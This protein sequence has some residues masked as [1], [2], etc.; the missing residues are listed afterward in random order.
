MIGCEIGEFGEVLVRDD[1]KVGGS[2][3]CDVLDNKARIVLMK[4]LAGYNSITD[5]TENAVTRH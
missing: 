5:L 2:L 3:G 4:Y 1:E